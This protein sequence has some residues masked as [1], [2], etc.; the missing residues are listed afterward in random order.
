MEDETSIAQTSDSKRQSNNDK[1]DTSKIRN[2]LNEQIR[3]SEN[4]EK[5]NDEVEDRQRKL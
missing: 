1:Q 5:Q 3:K 4:L 2:L